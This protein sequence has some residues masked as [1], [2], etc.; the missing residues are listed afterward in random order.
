MQFPAKD[1]VLKSL[2]NPLI[3]FT[4]LLITANLNQFNIRPKFLEVYAI[5][6]PVN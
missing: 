4:F 6:A 1:K 2:Q 5:Q 3:T